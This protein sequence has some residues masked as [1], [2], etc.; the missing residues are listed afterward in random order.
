MASGDLTGAQG[1]TQHVSCAAFD[2]VDDKVVMSNP[3]EINVAKN[4]SISLYFLC[5]DV[6]TGTS[7]IFGNATGTNDRT[8]ISTLSGT[9]RAGCYNGSFV[10]S[11]S[12]TVSNNTWTHICYTHTSGN[13]GA[14]Y[15]NGTAQVGTSTPTTSASTDMYVGLRADG[16]LPL[17]GGVR[18]LGIYERVLT[19]Q[20][21][22]DLSNGKEIT[23]GRVGYWKFEDDFNDADKSNNGTATGAFLT[24]NIGNQIVANFIGLNN[25]AATD[26]VLCA[27]VK[28]RPD[29]FRIFTAER[30][31]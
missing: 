1:M 20:E 3:P 19:A 25:A 11:K 31:A 18:K 17:E 5:T 13:T 28:G 21:A 29:Q 10:A 26:K 9:V 14:L 15:I 23:Q 8:G 16:T 7:T 6:S 30:E 2:G 27:M 12:G 22:Q 4:F 24:K